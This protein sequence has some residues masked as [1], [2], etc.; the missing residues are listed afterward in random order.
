MVDEEHDSPPSNAH[1]AS[2]YTNVV[3]YLTGE[4]RAFAK[5]TLKFTLL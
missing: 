3:T 2:I 1:D 4:R 5:T